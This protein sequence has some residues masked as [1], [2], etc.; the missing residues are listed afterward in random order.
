VPAP[1]TIR[2]KSLSARKRPEANPSS[3]RRFPQHWHWLWWSVAAL[4]IMALGAEGV[5]WWRERRE[6]RRAA[7]QD[8][9]E[10]RPGAIWVKVVHPRRG[11]LS[12]TTTQ[13]GVVH[14]FD[15]AS[16]YAKA[17]GYLQGQ[18]VDIGDTVERGQVLA[19]IYDPERLQAVEQAAADVEQAKAEVERS[20]TL[21]SV[22]RARLKAATALVKQ[23]QAEVAQSTASRAYR[24]KEFIRYTWL[25]TLQALEEQLADEKQDDFE[26]A[27]SGERA[28]LAAVDTAKGRLEEAA[29]DLEKSQADK[30]VAEARLRVAE[31]ALSRAQILAE[32]L[33]ITSPYDGIVTER[34]YHRGDFIRAADGG[35]EPLPVLSVARTDLMRVVIYVPDRDVPYVD[36]GDKAV[37]R[38]DA[39]S[40]EEFKGDVARFSATELSAS[41]VMRV[42]VDLPN[43]T[44]RLRQGMYGA[45]TIL[46]EPPSD[47]ILTVPSQAVREKSQSG[48]GMVYVVR[49]GK[50]HGTAV[51]VGHDN[52]LRT[53][54]L[55]GLAPSDEVIYTYSGSLEDGDPVEAEPAIPSEAHRGAQEKHGSDGP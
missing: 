49:D 43:P 39:L 32:Y 27:W 2:T 36:R 47:E 31:A 55:W 13:P 41:R 33:K 35:S 14:A 23:R 37:V 50:A 51:R 15:Y 29:A 26:S 10:H 48:Q 9:S 1:T 21:I 22:A 7:R 19:E 5:S 20:E 18:I 24:Q 8:R 38:I 6:E 42:E 53:E 11:G 52:G 46:L 44:G 28:A 17:S 30:K 4:L 12:R 34:N 45:V 3:R 16:L 25:V 40:G 54:I